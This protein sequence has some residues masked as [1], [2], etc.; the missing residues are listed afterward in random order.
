MVSS[1]TTKVWMELELRKCQIQNGA[2]RACSLA[3]YYTYT[4]SCLS[5][6]AL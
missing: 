1:G 6:F 3:T 5:L 2:E 4:A